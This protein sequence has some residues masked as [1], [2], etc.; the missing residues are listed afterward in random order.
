MPLPAVFVVIERVA[1]DELV[2]V[3]FVDA[4]VAV[5]VENDVL[6]A[7][8]EFKTAENGERRVLFEMQTSYLF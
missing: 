6:E 8:V 4:V 5:G 2:I 1:L 3:A 7:S